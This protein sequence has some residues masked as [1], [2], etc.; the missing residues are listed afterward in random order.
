MS[1]MRN[2]L[3]LMEGFVPEMKEL[4]LR[5]YALLRMIDT[6]GPI[7]RRSLALK[8]QLSERQVRNDVDFL[9]DQEMVDYL[10]EGAAITEK[11]REM[12]GLL[13]QLAQ[14]YS[15]IGQIQ[16]EI[17]RKLGI[18]EVLVVESPEDDRSGAL[19][20]MGRAAGKA[21]LTMLQSRDILG[22][23]GGTSV[24]SMVEQL[25]VRTSHPDG[26]MVVPARGGLGTHI[27]YQANTLVEKLAKK[28]DSEYSLLYMPD[29]LSSQAIRTLMDEPHI[30]DTMQFIRKIDCLV[31]GIGKA[32]VMAKRRRLDEATCRR[33]AE[34][35]AVAEA[36]GYFFNARGEIV[37]EISTF[38]I[39]LEQF[40]SLKRLIAIAGGADKAAAIVS[41]SKLNP[42]LVLVTDEQCAREIVDILRRSKE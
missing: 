12:I 2:D 30:R 40:H 16:K 41:I 15:G 3:D 25:S 11:G 13:Q 23:T 33:I 34:A 1:L 20:Q 32:D 5:R 42:N 36:F 6:Y 24:H 38:G 35:E 26:L 28:L 7:G 19:H 29:S 9:R 39:T 22:L 18:K 10:S 17:Q 4:F 27:R 14:H 31:F 37:F 8:S 21:L